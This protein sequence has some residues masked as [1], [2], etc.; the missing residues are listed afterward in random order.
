MSTA[1][2][3]ARVRGYAQAVRL[4]LAD[5]GPDVV[6]EL[7]DGLEADLTEAVADRGL[8]I[9]DDD[10]GLAAGI[11]GADQAGLADGLGA[12]E[13]TADGGLRAAHP[14]GID[15]TAIFGPPARY[16]AELRTAAGLPDA[17]AA[18][19]RAKGLA[20]LPARVRAWW[21]RRWAQLTASPAG[22][23]LRDFL[24]SLR[25][26]GWVA[27][28]WLVAAFFDGWMRQSWSLVPRH[29]VALFWF[30]VAVVVSVQWGRGRWQPWRWVKG[31]AVVAS[32][33]ALIGVLPMSDAT[34]NQAR[35]GWDQSWHA[36]RVPDVGVFVDGEQ[37]FN[38]FP[39]DAE[40]HPLENV[41]LFDERGR[42]VRLTP[43]RNPQDGWWGEVM[44]PDGTWRYPF[45]I[46]GDDGRLRWNVFPLREFAETD[47]EWDVDLNGDGFVRPR[48]GRDPRP[49]RWPFA[50]S[51]FAIPVPET[52]PQPAPD[53]PTG[54][55]ET[56]ADAPVDEAPV[57]EEPAEEAPG[58]EVPAPEAPVEEAPAEG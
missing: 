48:D 6:D 57:G 37:V 56:P 41:Q 3:D 26:F 2:I 31:L 4:H 47:V 28:G 58:G 32:V 38:L 22:A 7:T 9:P 5:L 12:V 30:L 40:G 19:T 45:G 17:V 20:T 16:A 21:D 49:I 14:E 34:A 29:G 50:L 23:A 44:T 51:P 46:A 42:P 36:P 39:Y 10:G 54:D 33:V 25:P 18:A 43:E 35:W 27:R 8:G 55:A 11:A 24:V 1:T 13:G 52:E 15:L 53:E